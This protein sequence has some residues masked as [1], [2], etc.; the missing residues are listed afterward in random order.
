MLFKDLVEKKKIEQ[1]QNNLKQVRTE[2]NLSWMQTKIDNF[3]ERQG[4]IFSKEKIIYEIM[5]NDI[6]AALFAKD[7]S[8]QNITEKLVT[9]ILHISKLPS[10]G[11]N[12]IRF[13]ETGEIVN[14]S[15]PNH[16]KSADFQINNWYITQK[17]TKEEGGAQDNQ[18]N[19]VIDFLT[20]GS[21]SHKVAALVD[22][23]YWDQKKPILKEY[24]KNNN[25]VIICGVDEILSKEVNF[26]N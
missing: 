6:V 21:I 7:P 17:Y 18:Y 12:C 23:D 9:E 26:E 4:K 20:K 19:D 2:I 10:Q 13:S 24:F 5:N 3:Y 16:T 11:K 1:R 22:G 15:K 8:K 14:T 25:N